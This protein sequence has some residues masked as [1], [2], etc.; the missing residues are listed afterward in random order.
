MPI[1]F[2]QENDFSEGSLSVSGILKCIKILLQGYNLVGFFVNG[3]PHNTISS[4]A[5]IQ[6]SN[7]SYLA[8]EGFHIF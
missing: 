5:Y 3:L 8:S 6:L 7:G 4:F 1:E 2:L